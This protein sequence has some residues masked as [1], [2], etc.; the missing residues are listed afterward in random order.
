MNRLPGILCCTALG[1]LAFAL[2]RIL[3]LGAVTMALVL[4]LV[5]ANLLRLPKQLMPGVGFCEKRVLGW[6]IALLGF[7]MDYTL[8]LSLGLFPLA[9]VISGILVTLGSAMLLGRLF[10]VEG[11][12]ALL[13]GVGNSFCGTSAI[14]ATQGVVAA[15]EKHV[16]LSIAVIN[17]LGTLG[18]FILPALAVVLGLSIEGRGLLIG[19]TLQAV[20]QVTAAGFGL[21]EVTGQTG[22]VIKL[23]RIMLLTP[24]ILM[25]TTTK[26]ASLPRS[27]IT[28]RLHIP[29]FIIAFIL[30]SIINSLGV[31]PHLLH[32]GLTVTGK[33]LLIVAMAAIGLKIRLRGLAGSGARALGLG[34]LVWVVQIG[35]SSTLILFFT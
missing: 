5:G 25:L 35:F 26:R 11:N 4:G 28:A 20:G 29:P 21:G 27:G 31:L 12:L 34:A 23:G 6:A 9:L 8:L 30:F 14:A 33:L 15:R 2:A 22:T 16:G 18:I 24:M 3:P 1:G 19:N 10:R 7:R 17:L 32:T 13:I